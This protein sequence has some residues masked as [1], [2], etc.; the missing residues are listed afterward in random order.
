MDAGARVSAAAGRILITGASGALARLVA[1]SLLEARRPED[2][3]VVSRTPAV[4][5]DLADRGV[6]VRF[7]DFAQPESLRAA[8]AGAGACS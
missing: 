2:L 8:F 7:G 4:L 3:I 6:D 1:Q 5:G